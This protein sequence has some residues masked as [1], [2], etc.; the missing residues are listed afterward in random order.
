M[1]DEKSAKCYT[2]RGQIAILTRL[3]LRAKALP[4]FMEALC[5]G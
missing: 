1:K 2:E 4:Q 5:L 3:I